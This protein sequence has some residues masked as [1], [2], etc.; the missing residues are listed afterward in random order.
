MYKLGDRVECSAYLVPARD[1]VRFDYIDEC[2]TDVGRRI[3]VK[4]RETGS[5]YKAWD[6]AYERTEGSY[7]VHTSRIPDDAIVRQGERAE[8]AKTYY[9]RREKLFRGI[10]VGLKD[11]VTE[12]MIIADGTEYEDG[13]RFEKK[14]TKTVPCAAVCFAMGNKKRTVPLCDTKLAD[15]Q[16]G[17]RL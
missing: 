1:G 8:L 2:H 16:I 13:F 14:P 10:V 11:V 9:V 5:P 15:G 4:C 12:G 17:I 6:G 7:I 3:C